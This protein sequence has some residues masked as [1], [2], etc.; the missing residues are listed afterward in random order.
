MK[1]D[2]VLNEV[3]KGLNF[4]ERIIVK[5]FQNV[6]IKLY[7]KGMIDCFNYYNKDGTF[8]Y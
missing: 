4:K 2:V 6:F 8:F 1:K 7:R 5:I 3:F